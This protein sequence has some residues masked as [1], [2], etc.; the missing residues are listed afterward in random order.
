VKIDS[1]CCAGSC[2]S[3]VVAI[4]SGD[5]DYLKKPDATPESGSCLTCVCRPKSH[6]VLDA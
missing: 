1:G 5:V 4:K 3:C 6:L 2:G